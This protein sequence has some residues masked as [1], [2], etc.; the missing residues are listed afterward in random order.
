M[1]VLILGAG[2]GAV[3][4]SGIV[5]AQTARVFVKANLI[6]KDTQSS[7]AVSV[8][9]KDWVLINASPDLRQQINA[10]PELWPEQGIQKVRRSVL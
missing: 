8:N 7:I 3:F 6:S 5:T 1:Q 4:L 2:A 10:N 9:G